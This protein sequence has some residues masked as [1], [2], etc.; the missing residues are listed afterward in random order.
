MDR[1]SHRSLT[2]GDVMTPIPLTVSSQLTM[3]KALELMRDNQVRHLLVVGP[4]KMLQGMLSERDLQ[5]HMSRLLETDAESVADRLP[6]LR[7]V[8][9]I[10]TTDPY[11]AMADQPLEDVVEMMS[12]GKFGAVPV[13]DDK[14]RATGVLSSIDLLRLLA[15]WLSKDDA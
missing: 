11:T 5:R 4:N 7:P 14:G 12:Q 3:H 6:M 13:V 15:A 2:V 10:M 9:E 8:A 1:D